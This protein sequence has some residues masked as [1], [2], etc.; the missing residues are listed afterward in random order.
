MGNYGLGHGA[1]WIFVIW[2]IYHAILISICRFI[3]PSKLNF[4]HRLRSALGIH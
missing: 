3:E 2:G 1:N 4:P